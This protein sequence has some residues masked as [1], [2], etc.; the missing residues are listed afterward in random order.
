M[1]LLASFTNP[2]MLDGLKGVIFDCDGVMFDSLESN[3]IY[4]N[5]ILER[6][7]LG[8]MT[9]EQEDYVH[10]HAVGESLAFIVPRERWDEIKGAQEQV[11]YRKEILPHLRPEP[12]LYE[13]LDGLKQAGFR[14][15]ISTNRTTTMGWLARRFGLERFFSPIVTARDVRPKPH[16]ESL[17]LIMSRW[18]LGPRDVAFLGDSSVD[19]RTAQAAGTRFW[20]F[21]NPAL[22]AELH[23]RDFWSMARGMRLG[24]TFQGCGG[25]CS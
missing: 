1:T 25:W 10:A 2:A 4:Y 15:G 23:V 13:L 17:H 8:P 18:R 3:R 21:R 14:L 9:P 20:A 16:P 12:G 7:G 22:T 6:L 11:D 24:A 5:T 19:M